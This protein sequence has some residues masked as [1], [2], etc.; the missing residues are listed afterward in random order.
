[1]I[2]LSQLKREGTERD[3][4]TLFSESQSRI[5]ITID[6]KNKDM[7]ESMMDS[8]DI[9]LIGAV[10]DENKLKIK[11]IKGDIVIDCPVKDLAESYNNTFKQF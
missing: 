9:S 2:D 3:D 6:P 8:T 5:I 10:T 4:F 1:M 11:S 7:F